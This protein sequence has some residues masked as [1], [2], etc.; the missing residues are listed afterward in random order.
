MFD[1]PEFK[2]L[3]RLMVFYNKHGKRYGKKDATLP[4]GVVSKKDKYIAQIRKYGK[5]TYIGTFDDPLVARS[6]YKYEEMDYMK[7]LEDRIQVLIKKIGKKY[8]H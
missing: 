7:D 1:S 6:A 4:I 8:L 5:T 3:S 2:E